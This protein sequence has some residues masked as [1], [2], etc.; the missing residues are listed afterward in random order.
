MRTNV[1]EAPH[2]SIFRIHAGIIL[3]DTDNDVSRDS[4]WVRAG[5][6][7][8]WSS[9]PGSVKNFLFSTLPRLALGSAQPSIQWVPEDSFPEGKVAGA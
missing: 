3:Q 8:G 4:K 2:T 9:S 6:P 1:S 7:R 5:R